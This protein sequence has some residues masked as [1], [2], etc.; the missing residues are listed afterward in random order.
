MV[1][2][3]KVEQLVNQGPM[4]NGV[5]GLLEIAEHRADLAQLQTGGVVVVLS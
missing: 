3:T 4:G 1:T 5:K 2:D